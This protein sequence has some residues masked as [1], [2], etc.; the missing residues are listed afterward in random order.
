MGKSGRDGMDA[1]AGLNCA[2]CAAAVEETDHRDGCLLR[3][4]RLGLR[5]ERGRVVSVYPEGRRNAE[6][7]R[8]PAWCERRTHDV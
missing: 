7:C 8:A 3:C 2:E 6:F 1:A 5:G 4:M